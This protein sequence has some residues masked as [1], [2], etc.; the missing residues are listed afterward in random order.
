M[1]AL[2]NSR[3]SAE[4]HAV[5]SQWRRRNA[6]TWSVAANGASDAGRKVFPTTL[7]QVDRPGKDEAALVAAALCPLDVAPGGAIVSFMAMVE[8]PRVRT[9]NEEFLA[10]GAGWQERAGD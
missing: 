6:R 7:R 3:A 5:K 9:D 10:L 8:P 2:R 4:Q 1:V